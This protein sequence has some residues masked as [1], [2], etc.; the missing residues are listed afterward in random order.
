MSMLNIL[1]FTRK[2]FS[3]A[4]QKNLILRDIVP[5][6]DESLNLLCRHGNI[7]QI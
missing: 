5:C 6:F 1:L 2:F 4:A 7:K 3:L